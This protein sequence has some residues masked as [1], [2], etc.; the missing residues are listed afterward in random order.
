MTK[1]PCR[2]L[3][4][5][6]LLAATFAQ[7]DDARLVVSIK[8]IRDNA[9]NLRVSLYR[10]PETFRKEERALK[11]VSIPAAK[12]EA[13]VIFDG[14]APGRYALMAYHDENADGKLNLRLGMFPTEGYALSNNPKV[15][16]PPKFADSAFEVTGPETE[17][18]LTLA[19]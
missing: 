4:L 3:A 13:R 17:A 15:M 5:A 1:S 14:L 7:A 2:S 18:S 6:L 8:E 10:D 9:G 19:Y 12:G 11:A 16:G